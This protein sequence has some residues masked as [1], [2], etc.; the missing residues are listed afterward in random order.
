MANDGL[1]LARPPVNIARSAAAASLACMLRGASSYGAAA[2]SPPPL[3]VPQ[4]Q[5]GLLPSPAQ[6]NRQPEL[7]ALYPLSP[8]AFK[9]QLRRQFGG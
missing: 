2:G 5:T 6:V 7:A 4:I 8:A 1:D 9:L 3:A